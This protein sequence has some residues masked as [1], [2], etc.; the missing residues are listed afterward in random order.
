M[1][2]GAPPVVQTSCKRILVA[3]KR[4]TYKDWDYSKV[5]GYLPGV[6]NGLLGAT[7][8]VRTWMAPSEA[9]VVLT[10]TAGLVLG[11]LESCLPPALKVLHVP[12]LCF[13]RAGTGLGFFAESVECLE[14][15][16]DA[17]LFRSM[18]GYLRRLS[19]NARREVCASASINHAN[20]P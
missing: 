14:T 8:G 5:H 18:S 2:C 4:S 9:L 6:L 13:C 17:R 11:I 12:G 3:R 10:R 15:A 16:C 7:R 1:N 19:Q 20:L